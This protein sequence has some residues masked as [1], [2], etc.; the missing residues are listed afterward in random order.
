MRKA[1]TLVELLIACS[2]IGIAAAVAAPRVHGATD[3]LAVEAAVRD[4]ASALALGRLSALRY[5]GAEVRFDAA[6]VSVR[7]GPRQILTRNVT[8]AHGV[9]LRSN[10]AAFRYAA[11]GL[12]AGVANGSV[13]VSRGSAA[14]TVV[15]SRLGRVR[16]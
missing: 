6:S 16:R 15:I 3:K 13:I 5:G 8:A 9:A 11:T 14:D 2:I 10:T 12:G 4:V 1:V 7:A